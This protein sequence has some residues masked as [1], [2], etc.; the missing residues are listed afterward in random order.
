MKKD[1]KLDNS[2]NIEEVAKTQQGRPLQK[3]QKSDQKIAFYITKNEKEA[4]TEV[5]KK[6]GLSVSSY[7]KMI[8]LKEV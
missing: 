4:L 5:A 3:E 1:F 7:A 2:K 6:E 8:L